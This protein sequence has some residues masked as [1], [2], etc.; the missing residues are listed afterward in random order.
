MIENKFYSPLK[1]GLFTVVLSYFLFTLHAVFTLSWVGE[2]NRIGGG[3]FL[4]AIYAE[5]VSAFAGDA[6]RFAASIIALA[7]IIFYF[8]KK[9]ISKPAV[10]KILRGILVLEA[11]YWLGL[12]TT[13]YYEVQGLFFTRGFGHRSI[14]FVLNSF[15]TSVLPSVLESLAIPIVLLIFAYKLSPNKPLKGAIRWGLISGT[16]IIFVFWLTNTGSWIGVIDQKGTGYLTSHPQH[17][18][19]FILT[20]FGLLALAIYAASFTFKSRRAET[21]Q[22]LNLK[23]VGVIILALGMY[24]LWNYLSWIFFGGDY[25]WSSWYAWFLGHNLDLWMLSLPLLG[26]PLLFS[27][28]VRPENTAEHGTVNQA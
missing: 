5:D 11:I 4:F 21:I 9:N 18:L 24:F 22:E 6:F 16:L 20:A 14:M 26:L 12:A 10:Y 3:Q 27:N 23:I 8:A 28:K 1:I 13:A 25:V 7:A 15:G 17:I 2:W 19:S